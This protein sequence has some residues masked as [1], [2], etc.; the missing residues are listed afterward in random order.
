M[1]NKFWV[2]TNFK[3][4][5][6]VLQV[7]SIFI[8]IFIDIQ[9]KIYYNFSES[10]KKYQRYCSN[11]SISNKNNWVVTE[12]LHQIKLTLIPEKEAVTN[13]DTEMK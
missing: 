2:L 7:K 9:A 5:F 6:R 12:P 13:T 10:Q 3:Q 11:L 1:I 4:V 8:S